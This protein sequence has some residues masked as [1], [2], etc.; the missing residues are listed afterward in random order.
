MK[1]GL[2]DS[3]DDSV[4]DAMIFVYGTLKEGFPNHARNTGQR[5]P[6][7]YR[8]R[9]AFPLYV[10]KLANEDRAP[11]LLH[12]PGEGHQVSGQVFRV[13]G[14]AL[15]AMDVFEEVGLPTGY[16]R[17]Q[18]ELEP[19]LGNG[20]TIRA[21]AYMKPVDRLAACLRVEGPYPEYTPELALGY[22]LRMA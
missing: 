20:T 8:T 3:G 5:V 18:I 13:D 22:Q 16:V 9:L 1:E 12:S 4:M 7:S 15:L 2:P 11:W 14:A 17:A 6:G 21:H 19:C 10:V